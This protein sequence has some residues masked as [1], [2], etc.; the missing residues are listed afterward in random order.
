MPSFSG[1]QSGKIL[2]E[3]NLT[4][5]GSSS[6]SRVGRTPATRSII[7]RRLLIFSSCSQYRAN[8]NSCISASHHSSLLHRIRFLFRVWRINGALW[9]R[10]TSCK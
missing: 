3:M 7:S 2:P 9:A 8:S 5:S 6:S 10:K 1:L 4:K